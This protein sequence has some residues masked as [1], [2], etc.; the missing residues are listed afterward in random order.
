MA[1]YT[2]TL[3]EI[4]SN[5]PSAAG[6]TGRPRRLPTT[7][8]RGPVCCCAIVSRDEAQMSAAVE[9]ITIDLIRFRSI[10]LVRRISRK[11]D[12]RAGATS[13]GVQRA[14]LWR[15]RCTALLTKTPT[16][17]SRSQDDDWKSHHDQHDASLSPPGVA[18]W[19]TARRASDNDGRAI[20]AARCAE[21]VRATSRSVPR[22][23]ERPAADVLSVLV[24]RR[25][26]GFRRSA[27]R[28]RTLYAP[29]GVPASGR[30]GGR[31]LP[32]ALPAKLLAGPQ[33]WRRAGIV[34]LHF[35]VS[36]RGRGRAVQ[37]R[38]A[39]REKNYH[40]TK[41]CWQSASRCRLGIRNCD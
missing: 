10:C 17:R 3:E 25:A 15:A 27:D 2:L 39:S 16:R 38:C 41:D 1:P 36:V 7:S 34:L 8:G 23:M 13:R 6:S 37:Y 30:D 20:H 4:P 32:G 19:G 24:R 31:L 21:A 40:I 5:D 14:T 18:A 22:A 28:A 35:S 26:R 33:R 29:G 12:D 11:K 9:R